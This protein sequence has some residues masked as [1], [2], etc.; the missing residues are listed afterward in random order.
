[1]DRI[2]IISGGGELPI[3]IGK[4]LLKK[5]YQICFF[6]IKGY[7]DKSKYDN[8][9]NVEIT[10]DSFSKILNLLKRSISVSKGCNFT[11]NKN[12]V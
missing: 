9:E 2:G 6:Y 10:I 3:N 5:N 11:L 4:S 8:Y 12:I 1:M 7:S